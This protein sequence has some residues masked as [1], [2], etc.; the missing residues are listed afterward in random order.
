[1][2]KIIKRLFCKH[3]YVYYNKT[4]IERNGI[5]YFKYYFVCNKCEKIKTI[6]TRELMDQIEY[7]E[8]LYK[9]NEVLGKNRKGLEDIGIKFYKSTSFSYSRKGKYINMLLDSY[10]DIGID[11]TEICEIS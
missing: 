8:V 11:L 7:F 9:K 2:N 5:M 4:E 6:T 1:M 10:R 3:E